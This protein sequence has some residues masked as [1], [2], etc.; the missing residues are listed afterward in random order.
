MISLSDYK[1]H[2]INSVMCEFDDDDFHKNERSEILSKRYDDKFLNKIIKDTYLFVQ[3]ILNSDTLEY[4]FCKIKLKNDITRFISL[5]LVG[6]YYSDKLYVDCNNRV[7]SDFILKNI[8]G[9]SISI[10]V[11]EEEVPFP[12]DEKDLFC[13]MSY[14]YCYW[15]FIQGFPKNMNDIKKK[16][17]KK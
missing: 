16:I 6:G 15:L 7:I 14:D 2:L 17:L 12:C 8:F 4:G 1:E 10:D 13:I 3:D 5:N 11:R 9:D